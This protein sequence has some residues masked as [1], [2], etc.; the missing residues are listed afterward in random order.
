MRG[1][2]LA[3]GLLCGL[4][5][6]ALAQSTQQFTLPAGGPVTVG[7]QPA[8]SGEGYS[9]YHYRTE[10]G[11]NAVTV[12]CVCEGANPERETE[13]CPKVNYQCACPKAEI[14]CD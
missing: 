12:T 4:S 3:A 1:F 13:Q 9:V 10:T 5:G 11:Q 8:N 6:V 7:V 14:T 2:L